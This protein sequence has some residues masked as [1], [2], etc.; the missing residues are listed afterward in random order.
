MFWFVFNR[1][2][3][4][5]PVIAEFNAGGF[6]ENFL[7]VFAAPWIGDFPNSDNTVNV[8]HTVG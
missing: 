7:A 5:A 4:A 6:L 1:S 8:C 3:V 2:A